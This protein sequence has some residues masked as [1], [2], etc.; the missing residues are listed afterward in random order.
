MLRC[1][2]CGMEFSEWA[3]R[4]P[5]CGDPA[6]PVATPTSG[7]PTAEPGGHARAPGDGSPGPGEGG[8][9]GT[10]AQDHTPPRRYELPDP[11]LPVALHL[12]GAAARD[13]LPFQH[14][15]RVPGSQRSVAPVSPDL[16]GPE[17]GRAHV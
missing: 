7:A 14:R 12:E 5:R 9:S 11:L 10:G 16:V 1:S 15:R 13:E 4:C 6:D 3:A 8:G 17:I 2:H